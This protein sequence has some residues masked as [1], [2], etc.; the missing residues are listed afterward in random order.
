MAYSGG[1]VMFTD[2][3]LRHLKEWIEIHDGCSSPTVK[4]LIERL[5]AAEGLI[6]WAVCRCGSG[7][8]CHCGYWQMKEIWRKEAGK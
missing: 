3:D 2:N 8:P 7:S 1:E 5:E 4:S 6:A